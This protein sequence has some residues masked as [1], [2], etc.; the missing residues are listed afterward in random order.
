M[1]HAGVLAYSLSTDQ[2]EKNFYGD[3]YGPMLGVDAF[4]TALF[5]E[6][7]GVAYLQDRCPSLTKEV[8]SWHLIMST[9]IHFKTLLAEREPNLKD[10]SFLEAALPNRQLRLLCVNGDSI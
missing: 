1:L 8:I 10:S 5:T 6:C 9:K 2:E 4:A 3:L 7:Q